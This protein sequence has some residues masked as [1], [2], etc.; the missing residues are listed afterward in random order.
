MR[1]RMHGPPTSAF[2]LAED[3]SAR[4]PTE[5]P[6]L[7][8]GVERARIARDLHDL[9]GHSLTTI[10]V[11]AGLARRL[12]VIDPERASREIT[13][14]EDLSRRALT[15]VRA[16]VSSYREVTLAG[17]LEVGSCC[18]HRAWQPTSLALPMWLTPPTKSCSAGPS[19]KASPASPA[20]LVPPPARSR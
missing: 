1:L 6:P 9:L 13:E 3:R 10:T 18:G 19:V 17:E 7:S 16:A 2:T 8:K 15:E 4:E 20:T 14:V 5:P 12:A 11:K